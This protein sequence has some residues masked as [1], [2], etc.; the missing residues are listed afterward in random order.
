MIMKNKISWDTA[1]KKYADKWLERKDVSGVLVCGS[2]VTGSPSKRSDIDVC[3]LLKNSAAWRARGNEISDGFL[4]EYFANPRKQ[5]LN[6]F[7]EEHA[8]GS[9][10]TAHMYGAGLILGDKDGSL[11]KLQKEARRWAAKKFPVPSTRFRELAKYQ[12]WDMSDGLED[13][14]ETRP[15]DLPHLCH[16]ALHSVF[17][18]YARF[19]GY[20]S[21]PQDKVLKSLRG[22]KNMPAFPDRRFAALYLEA[23][24]ARNNKIMMK[25]YRLLSK[26]VLSKMGGFK[27]NGWRLKS[28]LP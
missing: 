11:A 14:C 27:I 15:E 8:E 18:L 22:A 16:A 19:A 6:Y 25:A 5:V 2:Y 4:F 7:K 20:G 13:A 28:S 26:H 24:S 3:V 21:M 12:L 1:A 23:A 10:C 9:K 17:K